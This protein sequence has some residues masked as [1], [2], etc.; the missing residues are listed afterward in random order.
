[1]NRA[2]IG[3]AL[4][5]LRTASGKEAKAVAR[6]ALMSPSKLSKI[7]NAKLA[8]SATD[9]ERIL[10]AIGVSDKVKA[11]YA[12]VA[13]ASATETTAWRLLKRIGIHKGQQ[14]AKALEAQ[15]S[16]LRLF[17]PALVP[18][19][20]QTPEYIRAVLQR[21]DLSEDTLSRT[22]NGRLERQAVL[23]DTTKSLRFIITEPV[24]RWRIVRPQMMAAQLDRIVSVSRLSH[25]DIR[26]VPLRVQQN[27]I[28]NHAFVI[29]DDRMA[30][31]ET[32]HAEVMVTDP[33]D[34]ALYVDKF[35]GFERVAL[36][37][38]EA[39]EFVEE[40]RNEFLREQETG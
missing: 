39:R 16:M 29:R 14:D 25:V 17:Q 21:H 1:M 37:G 40:I 38:N 18:G 11:E 15:M 12:E 33:Q 31:V 19:L 20:L 34:V 5:T 8:P 6:S 30:T 26:V 9:V 32:V 23:Y 2:Q 36:T 7:E 22:I 13:R 28:A 27:D 24:L 10:T 35:E 4:R 3:A